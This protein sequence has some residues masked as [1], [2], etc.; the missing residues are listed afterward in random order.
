MEYN[1]EK[2]ARMPAQKK[3]PAPNADP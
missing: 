1:P 3:G 2:P